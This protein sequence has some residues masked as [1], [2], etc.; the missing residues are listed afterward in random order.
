MK[1]LLFVFILCFPL[2]GS[3]AILIED[4]KARRTS[5]T[6]RE[7]DDGLALRS[8]RRVGIGATAAGPLGFLGVNMELN[9]T[10][11]WGFGAGFGGSF[12][13]YQAYTFQVKHVL[14]GEWL[15]PYMSFGYAKWYTTGPAKGRIGALNPS[16]LS[17]RFLSEGQKA[18][19]DFA[20]HL[21][22]PSFGLQYVQL[23]GPWAGTSV[24]A[25]VVVLIDVDGLE[26]VPTGTLGA[27]YYF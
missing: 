23:S 12:G 17:D 19:G 15:L 20:V 8:I 9:F 25:E 13:E 22:Y 27:L 16:F 5:T 24:Y 11:R 18:A 14:A 3:A 6:T 1:Q 21:I 7:A 10:P 26:T 2:I 4:G